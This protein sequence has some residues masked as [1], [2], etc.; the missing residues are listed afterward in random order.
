MAMLSPQI[1]SWTETIICSLI[2][3]A[4]LPASHLRPINMKVL[5]SHEKALKGKTK[6]EVLIHT[7]GDYLGLPVCL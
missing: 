3:S 1:S 6:P 2:S 5:S 4:F 7:I